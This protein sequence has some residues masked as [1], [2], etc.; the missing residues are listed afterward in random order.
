MRSEYAQKISNLFNSGPVS[1]T[2]AAQ[3]LITE[4]KTIQQNIMR[5]AV[6]WLKTLA[7]DPCIFTD[8]RN[9]QSVRIARML[10]EKCPEAFEEPIPFI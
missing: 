4:H 5:F 8:D 1:Q 9:E 10:Y 7:T 3:E 6:T 2:K